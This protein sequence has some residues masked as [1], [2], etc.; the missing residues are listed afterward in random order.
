MSYFLNVS[1]NW[2]G[3]KY[4]FGK[5]LQGAVNFESFEWNWVANKKVPWWITGLGV[6]VTVWNA[7]GERKKIRKYRTIKSFEIDTATLLAEEKTVWVGLRLMIRQILRKAGK[8]TRVE[9]C[10]RWGRGK[11]SKS[12]KL[13]RTRLFNKS[14]FAATFNRE[15]FLTLCVCA[16]AQEG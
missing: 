9:G 16:L 12:A 3:W 4:F 2:C 1:L 8:G 5:C 6:V 14:L 15:G 10:K 13:W 11:A 7:S